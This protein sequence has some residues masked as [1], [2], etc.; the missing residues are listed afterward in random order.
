MEAGATLGLTLLR[1]TQ[2]R[3][4]AAQITRA[5]ERQTCI[6]S[7]RVAIA[8]ASNRCSVVSAH[9]AAKPSIDACLIADEKSRSAGL[10]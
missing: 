3:G 1:I 10:R 2:L 8:A 9:V 6:A 5:F 4:R 7:R